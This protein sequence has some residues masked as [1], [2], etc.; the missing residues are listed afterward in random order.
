[1]ADLTPRLR[2]I[3]LEGAPPGFV[4]EP[5]QDLMLHVPQGDGAIRRRYTIRRIDDGGRIEIWFVLHGHG[6]AAQ[7]AANATPGDTIVAIG[8][9]GKVIPVADRAWHLLAGDESGVAALL[10]MA[11]SIK[12]GAVEVIVEVEGAEDE[13]EAAVPVRWL[14][15][16]GV[17]AGDGDVLERAIAE[18]T[19]PEGE[20]HV[21]L[22]AEKATV[23][24]ISKQ[25]DERGVDR[26]HLAPKA[27][28]DRTRANAAHGEPLPDGWTGPEPGTPEFTAMRRP[29]GGAR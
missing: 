2:A 11:E 28:W 16:D 3:W 6:P 18:L 26:D 27:Y 29:A 19:L 10:A 23:R 14:H 15:R 4:Y 12:E 21:Y 8:P 25:L 22:A 5:G 24:R 7:W 13:L 1:M 9:R 20:G 17:P